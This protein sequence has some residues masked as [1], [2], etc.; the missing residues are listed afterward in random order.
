M[1]S[2]KRLTGDNF[3]L[4]ALVYLQ[5]LGYHLLEQNYLTP[6]GEIDLIMR[7]NKTGET[8]FVEV[9]AVQTSLFGQAVEKITPAKLAKIKKSALV[10]QNK[11][12][13]F[14]SMRFDAVCFENASGFSTLKH[15][16]AIV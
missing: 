9:K 7:D 16:Q 14:I 11:L 13:H 15:F 3:E 5:S 6:Y 12:G 10:Y 2:P 1:P 4:K 8:V